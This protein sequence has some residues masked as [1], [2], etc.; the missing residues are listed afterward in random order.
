MCRVMVHV[1]IK[2][3]LYEVKIFSYK[4]WEFIIDTLVLQPHATEQ[5]NANIAQL[6]ITGCFHVSQLFQY[7]N[8]VFTIYYIVM[9]YSIT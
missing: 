5:L 7:L 8:F 3:P 2:D 6:D 4:F 9:T 1:S